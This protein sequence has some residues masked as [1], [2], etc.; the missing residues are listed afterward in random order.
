MKKVAEYIKGDK[1]IWAIAGLLALFSFMPVYSASSNIAFMYSNGNTTAM[2][3]KHLVHLAIGFSAMYFIHKINYKYFAGISLL[4][5][6]IVLFLLIYTLGQGTTIGNANASRW[7]RIPVLGFTFQTSALASIALLVFL[8]RNLVKYDVKNLSLRDAVLYFLLPIGAVCAL[9]LPANF[10]TAALIFLLSMILLIIGY[11]PMKYIGLSIGAGLF[12][13]VMFIGVVLIF[14]NISNRVSTWKARIENFS[15][16]DAESNYQ[17]SKAKMAIAQGGVFGKGPGKSVQKNFLPQSNS[18]FIYA[19]IIEEFGVIT[20][21]L[22]I[23]LYIFLF[24]RIVRIAMRSPSPFGKYL[25][26]GLGIGIVFQAFINMAVAVNLIPVTGQTLPLVSAG[27]SSIWMTCIALG[28]IISVSR[29]FIDN[30]I[31]NPVDNPEESDAT[32]DLDPSETLSENSSNPE[33]A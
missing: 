29:S 18:D 14:P 15:A 33:L 21:L 17:V 12:G 6:P 13:L 9:I 11:F 2:L 1:V 22:I 8:A 20:G 25:S 16:G 31:D 32:E 10:S 26:I 4:V 30:S 3:I 23:G 24:F 28:M 19:V 27:G 7:I 5:G